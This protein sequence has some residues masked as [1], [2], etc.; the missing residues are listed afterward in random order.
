[1]CC[2]AIHSSA[3]RCSSRPGAS[4]W[5]APIRRRATS[6]RG[7][8]RRARIDRRRRG[9]ARRQAGSCRRGTQCRP[10]QQGNRIRPW[11]ALSARC[12]ELRR[13]PRIGIGGSSVAAAIASALRARRLYA[14]IRM[15]CTRSEMVAAAS[16][17]VRRAAATPLRRHRDTAQSGC[18]TDR[19]VMLTV[20]AFCDHRAMLSTVSR[21]PSSGSSA[22]SHT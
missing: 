21:S 10:Q 7:A 12:G 16:T 2:A 3:R 18:G 5:R 4:S 20:K 19:T 8:C 17:P 9:G 22:A 15:N 1:M 14:S 6:R 13:G 11:H